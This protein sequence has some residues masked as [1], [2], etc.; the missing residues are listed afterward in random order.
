MDE[1]IKLCGL[2]IHLFLRRNRAERFWLCKNL[3]GTTTSIR[4]MRTRFSCLIFSLT[5][6]KLCKLDFA[7]FL[8]FFASCPTTNSANRE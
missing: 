1:K 6:V 8:I 3:S 4:G 2:P 5:V 7:R